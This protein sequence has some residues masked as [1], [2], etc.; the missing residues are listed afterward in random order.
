MMI[1]ENSLCRSNP[2]IVHSESQ[3]PFTIKPVH[4]V[5]VH[6]IDQD[7][8]W[9]PLTDLQF[10]CIQHCIKPENGDIQPIRRLRPWERSSWNKLKL[11]ARR[12]LELC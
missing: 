10:A 12:N 8:G 9:N 3:V 2:T 1:S 4:K 11:I 6:D 5:A 7:P